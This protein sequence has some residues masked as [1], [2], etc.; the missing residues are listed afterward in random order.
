MKKFFTLFIGIMI[1]IAGAAY[2]ENDYQYVQVEDG[3]H[4]IG[5]SGSE[6][7]IMLPSELDG[8]IVTG[9]AAGAFAGNSTLV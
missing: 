9:V 7:V 1:L 8:Q 3:V 2:A 5:Y 6:S 4:I